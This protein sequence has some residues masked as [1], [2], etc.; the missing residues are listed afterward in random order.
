[1]AFGEIR[2][3]DATPQDIVSLGQII[4]EQGFAVDRRQRDHQYAYLPDSAMPNR[5]H[6]YN[7]EPVSV[8][9]GDQ[10]FMSDQHRH[11]HQRLPG[12]Q[13]RPAPAQADLAPGARGGHLPAGRHP[14]GL[15]S[16]APRFPRRPTF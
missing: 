6:Q 16:S 8:S 15:T 2:Y 4:F 5:L 12:L 3:G 14:A 1:M 13:L 9:D 10:Q 7:F 11:R